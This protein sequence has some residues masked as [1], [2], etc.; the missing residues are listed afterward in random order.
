MKTN[1]R[2]SLQ[3]IFAERQAQDGSETSNAA[4]AKRDAAGRS[5]TRLNAADH[6]PQRP[7][8]A[9]AE[10]LGLFRYA[11]PPSPGKAKPANGLP[12][13]L[14]PPFQRREPQP[15]RG[16]DEQHVTTL[17]MGEEDGGAPPKDDEQDVTTLAMGEEDGA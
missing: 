3:A 15:K 6:A 4:N 14:Q 10:K 17:A 16:D 12:G 9:A 2:K 8:D 11:M 5:Q 13:A 7:A 1:N